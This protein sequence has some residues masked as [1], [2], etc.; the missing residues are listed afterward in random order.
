MDTGTD[1]AFQ[2][3]GDS[4]WKI[5]ESIELGEGVGRSAASLYEDIEDCVA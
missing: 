3:H 2:V 4:S 5:G 1:C